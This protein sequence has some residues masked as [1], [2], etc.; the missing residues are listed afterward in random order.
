METD[1]FLWTLPSRKSADFWTLSGNNSDWI[2]SQG[3]QFH[4]NGTVTFVKVMQTI[5]GGIHNNNETIYPAA[6]YT[7]ERKSY[8]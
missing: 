5:N 2:T 3:I 6:Q 1:V 8:D 7:G 4:E